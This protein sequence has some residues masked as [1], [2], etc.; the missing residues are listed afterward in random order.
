MRHRVKKSSFN[1]DT[2]HRQAM[3][4]NGV[5]NLLLHGEI[6]TTRAKAREYQRWTDK[7]I[8]QAK[9]DS[10]ASRRALH[11][12]FGK[13]DIVNTLVERIVPVF[14]Q[15]QSGFTRITPAGVRR[16]DSTRLVK[17]ELVAKPEQLGSFKNLTV[18]KKKVVKKTSDR[19]QRKLKSASSSAKK[20]GSTQNTPTSKKSSQT[21][22]V[23]GK[24]KK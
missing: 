21:K 2:K 11:R 22:S 17:L 1:R 23:Q 15:R 9:Q 14:K 13:R 16:G 19:A 3:L 24:T 6:K 12:F 7:L 20:S 18:V 4:K 10:L 8:A 5:R